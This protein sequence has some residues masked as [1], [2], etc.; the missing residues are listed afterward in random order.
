[1]LLLR[2]YCFKVYNKVDTTIL[3][4]DDIQ[5]TVYATLIVVGVLTY[6][7]ILDLFVRVMDKWYRLLGKPSF[8]GDMSYVR[9]HAVK[10]EKE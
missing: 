10:L 2:K 5:N 4:H 6:F 8:Q 3:Y 1:M 9:D 7:A